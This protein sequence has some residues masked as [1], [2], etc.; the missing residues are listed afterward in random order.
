MQDADSCRKAENRA[1][2]QEVRQSYP[3]ANVCSKFHY[4]NVL[5]NVPEK[6]F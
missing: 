2:P 3:R 6:Q 5:L 1:G 4:V